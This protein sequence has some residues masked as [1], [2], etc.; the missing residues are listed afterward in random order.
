MA[1]IDEKEIPKLKGLLR[2]GPP[3]EDSIGTYPS[4]GVMHE[5][6]DGFVTTLGTHED[7][8]TPP[9]NSIRTL[10]LG[11][12]H[13]PEGACLPF[14]LLMG[15]LLECIEKGANTVGMIT[16]RGPCRLG[17]YSLGMRLIF[18]DLGLNVGWFDF[19]NVNLRKGYIARMRKVHRETYGERLSYMRFGKSFAIGFMRLGA[20]EALEKERNLRIALE[21]EPGSIDDCFKE[22]QKQ[23]GQATHPPGIWRALRQAKK[24]LRAVPIDPERRIVKVVITGEVY[25]VLDP[26]ANSHIETRLARLHAEPYRVI[27]QSSHLRYAIK[28]DLFR[29]DGKGAAIRAARGYL[30]EQLG[31]DCN[32][33]LGHAILAHR[34]GYDGM[35]HLKPFGC[36]LEFVAQNLLQVFEEKTGFPILSLTL[37]DLTADERI[38]NRLEAFVD[39]LFRRK[40]GS[41]GAR[42]RS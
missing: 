9:P 38:N 33:N 3:P 26:F 29:K 27:W 31:G 42:S 13:A 34:R 37:D 20:V 7:V 18:S 11:T 10:D 36:M 6:V 2:E 25:C 17:F 22:G 4:L 28:L 8:V 32:S 23:I 14:K 19:N 24:K 30:P 21:V 41:K 39:N 5:L 40:Y 12:M 35:V 1:P 16:E 15:N